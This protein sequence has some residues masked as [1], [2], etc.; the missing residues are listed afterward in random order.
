MFASSNRRT[1]MAYPNGGIAGGFDHHLDRAA[2]DRRHTVGR[3]CRRVDQCAIPP[4][5][6]ASFARSLRIEIDDGYDLQPGRMWHLRQKHRPELASTDQ[7]NANGFSRG[8]AGLQEVMEI[9]E[10]DPVRRYFKVVQTIQIIMARLCP[11]IHISVLRRSERG[12]QRH[13]YLRRFVHRHP[14]SPPDLGQ[15]QGLER[16]GRCPPANN[17][18]A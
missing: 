2:L 16:G 14:A 11:A 12:C 7:H 1:S 4:H 3:E 9:H 18:E 10:T 15:H 6:A 17:L 13:R 5:G 8:V